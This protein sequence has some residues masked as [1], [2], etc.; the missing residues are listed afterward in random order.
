MKNLVL[1]IDPG[2][3]SGICLLQ[4]EPLEIVHTDELDWLG[5]ARYVD[6]VL[7]EYGGENVDVVC[8]RFT[9]TQQT[10]KN[11]QQQWSIEII[12]MIRLLCHIYNAGELKL[13]SPADAKRFATNP[14][15][16]SLD[17][18]HVGGGGHALDAIRH[19]VLRL[20]NLG[21]RDSRLLHE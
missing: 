5:T 21:W 1:A 3:T 10:A 20:T 11:S 6:Q 7:R 19:A 8:E 4:M 15:L 18:W 13:Q 9:I 2:L 16:K 17:L 12:G 14:R